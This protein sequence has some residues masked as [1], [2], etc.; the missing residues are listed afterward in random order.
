MEK[1]FGTRELV[2]VIRDVA[3]LSV[4][5]GSGLICAAAGRVTRAFT[6]YLPGAD[7]LS[8]SGKKQLASAAAMIGLNT[9]LYGDI[10]DPVGSSSNIW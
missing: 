6:I 2:R 5:R 4:A 1:I 3:Q 10:D 8:R 7:I 9:Y